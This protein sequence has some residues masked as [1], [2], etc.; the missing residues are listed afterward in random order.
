M[1]LRPSRRRLPRNDRYDLH[2]QFAHARLRLRKVRQLCAAPADRQRREHRLL[3]LRPARAVGIRRRLSDPLQ[4]RGESRFAGVRQDTDAP[5]GDRECT[6]GVGRS[7]ESDQSGVRIPEPERRLRLLHTRILVR[8]SDLVE[9]RRKLDLSSRRR[10]A[11]RHPPHEEHGGIRCS[12]RNDSGRADLWKH[13]A[14]RS[15]DRRRFQSLSLRIL[16]RYAHLP[17]PALSG[18]IQPAGVLRLKKQRS[19]QRTHILRR[20]CESIPQRPQ[21]ER[22]CRAERI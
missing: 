8:R 4:R 17:K 5:G 13:R 22:I 16:G 12:D 3:L 7:A 14:I 19:T 2:F 1:V 6:G 9:R 18:K 21:H 10:I 20:G 11:R 15:S